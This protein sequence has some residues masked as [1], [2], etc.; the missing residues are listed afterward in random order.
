MRSIK[1]TQA[2][3]AL[4]AAAIIF[5]IHDSVF[6]FNRIERLL[7]TD[8]TIVNFAQFF[9]EFGLHFF[10]IFLF[11]FLCSFNKIIFNSAAFFLFLFSGISA[12]IYNTFGILPDQGSIANALDNTDDVS[13]VVNIFGLVTYLFFLLILPFFLIYKFEITKKNNKNLFI[14]I[15]V[16][17]IFFSATLTSFNKDTR[18][19][20]IV[21]YSPISLIDSVL[22]YCYNI[23]PT[24]KNKK[25][26]QPISKVVYDASIN[27][28]KVKNLKVVLIIG[29][30]ARAKNFSINGYERETTPKLQQQKNLL[31]FKDVTPCDNLTSYSVSCILSHR[32][33]KEFCLTADNDE[34]VVKL[35][36]NL[37]FST[38]WLSTQK[39]VGDDNILLMLGMQAQNYIFGNNIAQNIGGGEIYDGYLL[40]FLDK[41]IANENDNFV[42]LHTRGSHF[43]FDDRYPEEFKKFTPTCSKR[44]PKDCVRQDLVNAYDNSIFYTDYFISSVIDHLKNQNAILFYIS[45]HG[46]FLGEDNIYYHGTPR[47]IEYVEHKVPMFFWMSDKLLAQKFYKEKFN[48]AGLK[49]QKPLS[50]DNIFDSLLNCSGVESKFFDR[51]LSICK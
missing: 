48:K 38:A 11:F 51:D 50:H 44:K 46:Q 30:S 18:R 40:D 37:G 33:S 42:V 6:L 27:P 39:A 24:I 20:A 22:E 3:A 2:I 47:K 9:F 28:N 35:F 5:F 34:S 1:V 10:L 49:I 31:S 32:T 16:I 41:E 8:S 17:L 13:D 15:S 7:V 23:R 36:E 21:S 19:T 26:L 25:N 45:D 29:E 12:F 43:L 14:I 4:V